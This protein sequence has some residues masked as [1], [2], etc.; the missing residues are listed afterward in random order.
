[1]LKFHE[2]LA[3]RDGISLEEA[4]RRSLA[5]VWN[6]AQPGKVMALITAFVSGMPHENNVGRNMALASDIRKAKFGYSPLYGYWPY[7]ETDP[8][9]GEKT[10]KKEKIKE[11][12]LLV[13][14]PDKILNNQ[15]KFIV[16]SWIQK[17]Q[18]EAA[19]IKYADSDIAYLLTASGT[20][21]KLGTWSINKL[22]EIY[23]QMKHGPNAVNRTFVFEAADNHSWA[24]KLGMQQMEKELK[25]EQG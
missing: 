7:D 22:A 24:V 23:S 11:D 21:K 2:Y 18:Q 9:T 12:S 19:V 25:N 5:R 17:Y 20:E 1:M 14:A 16:L 10:G 15:F 8:I 6:L 4:A 13:S 3:K